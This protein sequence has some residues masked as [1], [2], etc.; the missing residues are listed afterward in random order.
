MKILKGQGF[1]NE[2]A[3]RVT[4]KMQLTCNVLLAHNDDAARAKFRQG[5]EPL[6]EIIPE[7]LVRRPRNEVSRN[8]QVCIVDSPLK[9][10]NNRFL[11]PF[12]WTR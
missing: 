3:L 10:S 12:L 5:L 9:M 4:M 11:R 1:G 2:N 8:S 7:N 6:V